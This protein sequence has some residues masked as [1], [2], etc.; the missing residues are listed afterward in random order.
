LLIFFDV[1]AFDDF[2]GELGG[3]EIEGDVAFDID[4]EEVFIFFEKEE[5]FYLLGREVSG[6]FL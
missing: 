1:Y 3:G 4:G 6:L 2:L 5:E